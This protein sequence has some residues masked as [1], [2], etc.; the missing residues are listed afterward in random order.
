M[1]RAA[2]KNRWHVPGWMGRCVMFC[3]STRAGIELCHLLKKRPAGA[4]LPPPAPADAEAASVEAGD[5]LGRTG[6]E[7]SD[8]QQEGKPSRRQREI[9]RLRRKADL[10][11]TDQ[12]A[13]LDTW[14]PSMYCA[15]CPMVSRRAGSMDRE[16][17]MDPSEAGD[18]G[19]CDPCAA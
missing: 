4:G 15:L 16:R 7:P 13:L 17:E 8:V 10:Q 14:A 9:R 5:E 11:V 3:R 2:F 6:D 19:W 12:L 1:H 18:G